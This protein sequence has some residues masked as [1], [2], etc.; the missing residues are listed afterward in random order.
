[1]NYAVAAA[2]VLAAVTGA[3][4]PLFSTNSTVELTI[5]APLRELF[6][7]GTT[8][9]KFTATG[10]ISYRDPATGAEVRI[11][12]V[13][14]SV[15]G[16]T[17][18]RETECIFPKLKIKL[19]DAAAR[20]ASIFAGSD[21]LRIGT[22][23]GENPGEELTPKFGRL[24]NEKSP[25]REVFVYHLL[26][27][28]GVPTVKARAARITYVDTAVSGAPLVRYA[29]LLEDEDDAKKRMGGTGEITEAQFSNA[30]A[31]LAPEDTTRLAFAQAMIGNFDWCLTFYPGDTYRCDAEHPLWNI[32]VFERPGGQ[33]PVPVMADFDLA[34]M[35][36]G[37]HSWFQR[38]YFDG[39]VP[40]RSPVEIEVLSQVQRTRSLFS[41]GELDAA[42]RYFL[43]RKPTAYATLE[44]SGL[45][46]RGHELAQ[47]YLD[48]FFSAITDEAFY[49]PIVTKPNTPIYADA[50]KSQEACA[51]GDFA[52]RGSPVNVI[53][54]QGNMT[55]IT[56]LDAR[57]RWGWGPRACKAI[58]TGPV[59]IETDAIGTDYPMGGSDGQNR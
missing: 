17:S 30:R 14:L 6:D 12:E 2:F 11:P 27:A 57:W 5:R 21:G 26:D 13:E 54:S 8:D 18:K 7:K 50:A 40:S 36:V 10:V 25:L 48:A 22:H 45:D 49:R 52:L 3:D 24:A 9:D 29:M 19:R 4:R 42:R 16:H 44:R 15:R 28:M 55:Q 34:G 37:H 35:V 1:M 59:W 23:C 46:S 32:T 39:F 20:D 47:Q 43:D 33:P 38:V 53:T 51:P 41:R 58:T 31:Q 56:L